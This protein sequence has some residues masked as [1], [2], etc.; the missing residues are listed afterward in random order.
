MD[1]V[2]DLPRAYAA[3]IRYQLRR[4]EQCPDGRVA[5]QL[6]RSGEALGRLVAARKLDK[7]FVAEVLLAEAKGRQVEPLLAELAVSAG[8]ADGARQPSGLAIV[9]DISL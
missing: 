5:D 2:Y 4:I 7:R 3:A 8:L 9:H 1:L 6:R